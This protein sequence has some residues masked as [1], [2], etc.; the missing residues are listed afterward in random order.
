MG[1]VGRSKPER[2]ELRNQ[3]DVGSS[4]P[5]ESPSMKPETGRLSATH[6]SKVMK[7]AESQNGS[8]LSSNLRSRNEQIV[9]G[10]T[11]QDGC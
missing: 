8:S 1:G 9:A 7:V 2:A 6:A 3:I 5:P 11:K 4:V 10:A